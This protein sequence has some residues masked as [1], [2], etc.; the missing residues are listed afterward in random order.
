MTRGVP[1]RPQIAVTRFPAAGRRG[2][3]PPR[4]GGTLSSRP[5]NFSPAVSPPHSLAF[6]SAGGVPFL[7]TGERVWAR[8]SAWGSPAQR[9]RPSVV[10]FEGGGRPGF[11]R[12]LRCLLLPMILQCAWAC[13]AGLGV[14]YIFP[15]WAPADGHDFAA[16]HDFSPVNPEALVES[17]GLKRP[18]H[19]MGSSAGVLTTSRPGTSPPRARNR[20]A[21]LD[22]S[23]SNDWTEGKS[24][25]QA[26]MG[27]ETS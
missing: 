5:S 27:G 19:P 2:D 16:H 6:A 13:A 23:S 22:A 12:V 18:S 9:G 21:A 24:C 25:H 14:S 3:P 20:L 4:S 8:V 15:N 1:W 7:P 26:N 17:A 11:P 10:N